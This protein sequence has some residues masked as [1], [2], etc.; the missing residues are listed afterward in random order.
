MYSSY[1]A[2]GKPAYIYN[3]EQ[4]L[5]VCLSQRITHTWQRKGSQNATKTLFYLTN[6]KNL[7]NYSLYGKL[8][9]KSSE[10]H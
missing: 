5:S 6:K 2:G 1:E 9:T 3:A 10:L 7:A 8:I 4:C